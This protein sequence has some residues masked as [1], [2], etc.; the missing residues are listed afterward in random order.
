MEI[1]FVRHGEKLIGEGDLGL[2][3]VGVAQ[4]KNLAERLGKVNFDEF[5]S[6]NLNRAK[7]TAK[8]VEKK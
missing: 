4:A 7:E 5:Y 6:S 1:V 3:E 8:F 2:S